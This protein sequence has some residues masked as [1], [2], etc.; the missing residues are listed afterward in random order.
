MPKKKKVQAFP[1]PALVKEIGANK[2][3]SK[4]WGTITIAAKATWIG[5]T[6][7][8][9]VRPA[10]LR[11]H[12][13]QMALDV[14]IAN[15]DK[16][17][18]KVTLVVGPTTVGAVTTKLIA[19]VE[20]GGVAKKKGKIEKTGIALKNPIEELHDVL[21][22]PKHPQFLAWVTHN[23]LLSFRQV[24]VFA[25]KRGGEAELLA[26][27]LSEIASPAASDV[28]AAHE[29]TSAVY[30]AKYL[31]DAAVSAKKWWKNPLLASLPSASSSEKTIDDMFAASAL[32]GGKA[33]ESKATASGVHGQYS[34][35]SE[36]G[37]FTGTFTVKVV[38]VLSHEKISSFAPNNVLEVRSCLLPGV[39]QETLKDR[40]TILSRIPGPDYAQL[41][42]SV[43]AGEATEGEAID[44]ALEII[45]E[46]TE[47][48]VMILHKDVEL[49]TLKVTTL[50]V[51]GGEP[52]CKRL[53]DTINAE[54]ESAIKHLSD[55]FKPTS[56]DSIRLPLP[57]GIAKDKELDRN[58]LT[59]VEELGHG[60]F[61]EVY[62]ANREVQVGE[63][64]EGHP[65]LNGAVPENGIVEMQVAAKVC[66]AKVGPK[67][68]KE[69][70]MEAALQLGLDHPNIARVIGVCF[71]QK[72]F[73]CIL[74]LI[75]YGDLQ[76]VLQT[77][78]EK[79]IVVHPITQ[80]HITQQIAAG[81]AYI[82]ECRIVHLDLAAR[83][84]LVHSNTTMKIAD[85]GLSRNYNEGLNGWKLK[86]KMKVPFKWC[87]PEMLPK[88]LWKEDVSRYEP[89]FNELTDMWA[90]GITMWEIATYGGKPYQ[91]MKLLDAL[92]AIDEEKLRL[93]Y[94]SSTD[95]F[96]LQSAAKACAE[97]PK[98]RPTFAGFAA[99]FAVKLARR[100]FEIQDLG[101]LLNKP[102]EDRL[103][104][105]SAAVTMTKRAHWTILK[106]AIKFKGGLRAFRAKKAGAGSVSEDAAADA[107][108]PGPAAAAPSRPAL[109]GEKFDEG[110]ESADAA[111]TWFDA[112]AD[113]NQRNTRRASI[114]LDNPNDD[115]FAQ[116]SLY[117]PT[118]FAL[119]KSGEV[120]R[121]AGHS[122]V[123][124]TVATKRPTRPILTKS[125]Q[126]GALFT[127]DLFQRF[128]AFHV[129]SSDDEDGE[130]PEV[131]WKKEIA[132]PAVHYDATKKK[133]ADGPKKRVMFAEP[134]P[135]P[136]VLEADIEGDESEEDFYVEEDVPGE[137]HHFTSAYDDED[138]GVGGGGQTDKPWYTPTGGINT[139]GQFPSNVKLRFRAHDLDTSL[140]KSA[141]TANPFAIVTRTKEAAITEKTRRRAKVVQV[142]KTEVVKRSLDVTWKTIS[143]SP[144]KLCGTRHDIDAKLKIAVSHDGGWNNT[145]IGEASFSL[146]EIL[147]AYNPHSKASVKLPLSWPLINIHNVG[148]S[149]VGTLEL[150]SYDV[151]GIN[152]SSKDSRRPSATLSYSSG[153]F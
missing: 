76:K 28:V 15:A 103:R 65:A 143:I 96:F 52:Y 122:S 26:K 152:V 64:P 42:G 95:A 17:P 10:E 153:M 7:L 98:D 151:D 1:D 101:A 53:V 105:A 69:F 62:L 88:K 23:T 35:R 114:K 12:A 21:T 80:Y 3:V 82:T 36:V 130:E 86:G 66:Q 19:Q 134:E 135:E 32:V 126:R 45:D 11:K 33:L 124:E 128:H 145:V 113:G 41:R 83:N 118:A 79:Q 102:R 85:F 44:R 22:D 73:I 141:T 4:K 67:G 20:K 37:V 30:H 140:L 97:D 14:A 2:T 34:L 58:G 48:L 16:A 72:P 150:L 60:M 106:A 55:P 75:L 39:T 47:R 50:V 56:Q 78:S 43:A 148:S 149:H 59:A 125:F 38:D 27:R 115:H 119:G 127:G 31:G 54:K 107:T 147:E 89:M 91:G 77:C 40:S 93:V 109:F 74:E 142:Y 25:M 111:T 131:L 138:L 49:G 61:G 123:Q 92:K 68:V 71:T 137:T 5:S 112:S 81:M 63:L 144:E 121:V 129:D 84:C 46:V 146:Q 13:M 116:K 99:D 132:K 70:Q 24:H 18:E 108:P 51:G 29:E 57:E 104:N 100:E 120:E 87:P 90:L 6:L 117:D 9:A 8:G 133:K 136:E 110:Q 139:F 94:P